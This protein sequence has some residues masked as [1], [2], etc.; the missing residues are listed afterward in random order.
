MDESSAITL[1]SPLDVLDSSIGFDNSPGISIS[2]FRMQYKDLEELGKINC[3]D[4]GCQ[5]ESLDELS[6][7]SEHEDGAHSTALI[8]PLLNK[9]LNANEK[10]TATIPSRPYLYGKQL[11]SNTSKEISTSLDYF[12]TSN[13]SVPQNAFPINDP[14]SHHHAH[15][16]HHHHFKQN[17]SLAHYLL[18]NTNSTAQINGLSGQQLTILEP[19]KCSKLQPITMNASSAYQ[20]RLPN[21]ASTRT[22]KRTDSSVEGMIQ[23]HLLNLIFYSPYTNYIGIVFINSIRRLSVDPLYNRRRI[24]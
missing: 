8:E 1:P 7:V 12:K 20:G 10:F 16:Q 3:Y 17:D 5:Q 4:V 24:N 9:Q 13:G 18:D 23:Y 11:H 22:R 15:Y 6:N 21:V 14:V 19:L 2:D